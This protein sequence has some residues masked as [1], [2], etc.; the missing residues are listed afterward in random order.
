[1]IQTRP[2]DLW[3]AGRGLVLL[4]ALFCLIIGPRTRA[5]A[6]GAIEDPPPFLPPLP[7]EAQGSIDTTA[8]DSIA[9]ESLD[10]AWDTTDSLNG[11]SL[12]GGS[13]NGGS[14]NGDT[15]R[16]DSLAIEGEGPSGDTDSL[17][18]TDD[19]LESLPSTPRDSTGAPIDAGSDS[20][21]AGELAPPPVLV[22]SSLA[23]PADSLEPGLFDSLLSHPVMPESLETTPEIPESLRVYRRPIAPTAPEHPIEVPK[24]MGLWNYSRRLLPAEDAFLYRV[25][26]RWSARETVRARHFLKPEE[27]QRE[28]TLGFRY[29]QADQ[30]ALDMSDQLTRQVS[31]Q[32]DSNR[33][34]VQLFHRQLTVGPRIQLSM[35]QYLERLTAVS[36]RAEWMKQLKSL[37]KT[38]STAAAGSQGK[39]NLKLPIAIP[40]QLNQIFGKGEPNLQVRGSERI[41]F[42]G[43]SRWQP[44]RKDT[45]LSRGQSKFPQ[46][47]MMQELNINLTGTIGDKVTVDVDQASQA[48]TPLSNRIKINYKG[49]PDEIVQEVHLGNT[50]LSLPGTQYVTSG[51]RAE[52][53]FGINALA[54]FAAVD[55]T[56][57]LSKQEGKTDSKGITRQAEVQTFERQDLDYIQA[58]FFFLRDPNLCPWWVLQDSLSVFLDDR[59]ITNDV[60]LGARPAVVTNTGLNPHPVENPDTVAVGNFHLLKLGPDED[61][62]IQT[63]V[64]TGQPILVL[65]R[66]LSEN[67]ILAVSYRG[68]QMVPGPD[69]QLVTTTTP[70][71]RVGFIPA[72]G[73]TRSLKMIRPGGDVN[74]SLDLTQGPWAPIRNLELKNVY[75]LQ[76]RSIE[77]GSLHLAIRRKKSQGG[78]VNP[79]RIGD[80]TFLERTGLDL[81][82]LTGGGSTTPGQ[83]DEIDPGFVNYSE[84]TLTFPDLR[85]FDPDSIDLGFDP[86]SCGSFRYWRFRPAPPTR[87]ERTAANTLPFDPDYRA[88]NVYDR[89]THTDEA[90][91]SKYFLEITY[92]SPVSNIQLNAYNILPGSESVKAGGRTLQ[93]DHDYTID[94]D[95]GEIEILG[96]ANVSSNDDIQVTYSFIPFGGGSQ[97]TLA[98]MSGA[99]RP[100]DSKW[101]F[102]S[103]WLYESKGGVPGLQGK[104][105]RLGEEPSHTL[106]GE[107]STS[108]KTESWLLT[109]VANSLPGVTAR[110]P[111]RFDLDAG[112]GLSLPNP[113]TRDKLYIDDFDGV[114][115]IQSLSMNRRNW[116]PSSIPLQIANRDGD[117]LASARKGELYWYSPRAKVQEGDLQPTLDSQEGDDNRTVLEFKAFPAGQTELDREKSWVGVVQPLAT[118]G[119]DLSRAQFLDIWVNDFVRFDAWQRHERQ[120]RGRIHIDLGSVSEDALWYRA[121]PNDLRKPDEERVIQRPNGRLDTEDFVNPDGRL[122]QG[123]SGDEDVGLD[124]TKTGFAGDDPRDDYKFD[125]DIAESNPRKYASVN[126]TEG[127]QELD[128]ED[129][130]QDNSLATLNSYFSMTIDLADSSSWETDVYRDFAGRNDLNFPIRDDNGWRRI[131]IPLDSDSLISIVSRAGS[132]PSWEKIR[133]ARVW[134]DSL[135]DSTMIEIGGIEITG[136]RWF[137]GPI[138]KANGHP[139]PDSLTVPGEDFF[140]SVLNNKDDA[141]TYDPPFK[142]GKQNNITER[143]QSIT[144]ELANFPPGH[145]AS[146]YRSYTQNQDY[147]LYENM[148]FYLRQRSET[149]PV[150]LE[151]AIRLCR[152]AASDSTNYYEYRTPVTDDWSLIQID[153]GVLSRLQLELADSTTGLVTKDLGNGVSI[154]RK[155]SPSLTSVKRIAYFVTNVGST[156]LGRG[157]VWI[158]ELRLTQVKKDAGYASRI[159]LQASL[160]DVASLNASFTRTNA[161][162]LSIGRDRGSGT[163]ATVMNLGSSINVDRFFGALGIR[164]P[165]RWS[166]TKDRRV[167]KFQTNSDLVL[168]K[169]SDRDIAENAERRFEVSLSKEPSEDPLVRYLLSPFNLSG[170]H[171]RTTSLAPTQRDTTTSAS[172]TVNWSL[173]LEGVGAINLGKSWRAQFLPNS[174]S[175][176]LSGTRN[177]QRRYT[178]SDLSKDFK[179]A[180]STSR[181]TAGLNLGAG[182]R[183]LQLISYHIDSNRDL[184]LR[185]EQLKVAGL[186]L[187]RETGRHHTLTANYDFP[188]FKRSVAPKVSWTGRSDLDL[189]QLTSTQQGDFERLNGFR[190]GRTTTWSGRFALADFARDLKKL[191]RDPEASG[192]GGS[193]KSR[194]SVAPVNANYTVSTDTDFRRQRGSPSIAYQLG[195]ADT[196]GG[197]ARS[198]GEPQNSKNL[199][200]TLS[201]DSS[202]RGPQ[203][204]SIGARYSN[205]ST[206]VR[207]SAGAPNERSTRKWPDLSFNWGSA[208]KALTKILGLESRVKNITATTNYAVDRTM[209]ANQGRDR[210]T[211]TVNKAFAPVLNLTMTFASGLS[212]TLNSDSRSQR[213]DIFNPPPGQI[214][215]SA[216]KKLTLQC[217]KTLHLTKTV[218][219]PVTNQ[220]K[221]VNTRLDLSAGVDWSS[222]RSTSRQLGSALV[223]EDDRASFKV[224]ADAGYQFSDNIKG[225]AQVNVGQETNKKNQ[226]DTQRS[227][228]I[229]ISAAFTF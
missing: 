39:V 75:D 147:T 16:A 135:V 52:G 5:G 100:T 204:V 216:Q 77:P 174:L 3:R 198:V 1:M 132:E 67:D 203:N 202:L 150:S 123:S 160:S 212:A 88:P 24:G 87:E 65:N 122:D 172:G 223:V 79:D 156:Q 167:P 44:N 143:E 110:A 8:A 2:R 9:S 94:Y 11:G 175:A 73:S 166:Y 165:F 26:E 70:I 72:D 178:R 93:R 48:T 196:P 17:S 229:S 133:H 20:T 220:K 38:R 76:G 127:N 62:T 146:I 83:D 4:L 90:Q 125:D 82:R 155:G 99:Y 217:K 221:V 25:A 225:T 6:P 140:V 136:N 114:K 47:D 91:D 89:A 124:S 46:L 170:S 31:A 186:G 193:S 104:R 101:N 171:R 179:L 130:N 28:D 29:F 27:Q 154:S 137:E 13:L 191:G 128:T 208:P 142:P 214:R 199:T 51:G 84:G 21:G 50:N 195:L 19:A 138:T 41:T 49:Y 149:G 33:V 159:S 43:T 45:E 109:R 97:K 134:V 102:A 108:Y 7:V 168:D 210:D 112:L 12:N 153:F 139:L 222:N 61:Y 92:R 151:A 189:L 68:V 107:F 106:V 215:E 176:V 144:L 148:E 209:T 37:E 182:F 194:F 40:G 207:S 98:G 211:E 158:D 228:G 183:P 206:D 85:P 53:L 163:T 169:A 192:G 145:R 224:N 213:T 111:S 141:A 117:V 152:D 34:E 118:G 105:P 15:P 131:R 121:N 218:V 200:H 32:L 184:M 119:I 42:S 126:G 129:M 201:F 205:T 23:S 161:D 162:F 188:L 187:G 180:P 69:F 190:S 35:D 57:I 177:D 63:E 71:E 74:Q 181:N 22:D 18:S 86:A 226:N 173:P 58:K 157:N 115:D 55:V 30:P 164:L 64:Y 59:N 81:G 36:F 219:V 95:L 113:N 54:K 103:A 185:E 66:A 14:F 116:Q 120:R 80:V 197:S 78:E 56:M 60:Q 227:I 10:P 96:A